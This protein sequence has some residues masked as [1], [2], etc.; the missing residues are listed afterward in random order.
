MADNKALDKK[1]R[2][3]MGENNRFINEIIS[4]KSQQIDRMNM[5]NDQMQEVEIMREKLKIAELPLPVIEQ[6]N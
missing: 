6:I 4:L 5:A 3:L 2:D 1:S